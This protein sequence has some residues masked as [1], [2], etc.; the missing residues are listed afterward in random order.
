MQADPSAAQAGIMVTLS[1][2]LEA[3]PAA[4][5]GKTEEGPRSMGGL[6]SRTY[7]GKSLNTEVSTTTIRLFFIFPQNRSHE[8]LSGDVLAD[9]GGGS[10]GSRVG[11]KI[12][13]WKHICR[14]RNFLT[15]LGSFHAR[16]ASLRRDDR[17]LAAEVSLASRTCKKTNYQIK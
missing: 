9:E 5:G 4:V 14:Y 15:Y 6:I 16:V 11:K 1:S 12:K 3:P 7:L 17:S 10:V 13:F 2:R 8:V